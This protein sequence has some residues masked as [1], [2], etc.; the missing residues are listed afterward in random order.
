MGATRY[1]LLYLFGRRWVDLVDMH[2]MIVCSEQEKHFWRI[3][4]CSNWGCLIA[5]LRMVF[6]TDLLNSVTWNFLYNIFCLCS[7]PD[8]IRE[9]IRSVY[10]EKKYAGGRSSDKP[11]R[12]TQ[13]NIATS[14]N[15]G[16]F[17]LFLWAVW[18]FWMS[19]L[20][21]F[22]LT[23]FKCQNYCLSFLAVFQNY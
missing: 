16:F 12:D 18:S 22:D 4:T 8:R 6:S 20:F 13:V 19:A 3:G 9:F 2:C 5:G 21:F 1:S 17:L 14:L 10:V 7:K 11:P 23:M 15:E